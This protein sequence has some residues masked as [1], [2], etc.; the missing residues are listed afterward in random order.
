M[1]RL[2]VRLPA[3]WFTLTEKS[4]L[5]EP[6]HRA[7]PQEVQLV[8]GLL[9]VKCG[10]IGAASLRPGGLAPMAR[11]PEEQATPATFSHCGSFRELQHAHVFTNTS[12]YQER[13][14]EAA[15]PGQQEKGDFSSMTLKL[16]IAVW[17]VFRDW[18]QPPTPGLRM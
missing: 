4:G 3:V 6:L 1:C 16:L 12:G 2:L 18:L 10:V 13:E 17:G 7:T 5:D 14:T 15:K 9:Q 11:T 8:W